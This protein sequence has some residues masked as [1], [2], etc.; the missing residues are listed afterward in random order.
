MRKMLGGL[1]LLAL[2]G[3]GEVDAT[4][5]AVA[6]PSQLPASCSA[7]MQTTAIGPGGQPLFYE[8]CGDMGVELIMPGA[9]AAGVAVCCLQNEPAGYVPTGNECAAQ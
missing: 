7:A 2:V 5:G 1:A 8:T 4:P 9:M 6:C 3:C